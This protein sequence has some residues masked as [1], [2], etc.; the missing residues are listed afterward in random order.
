[1]ERAQ[2]FNPVKL[3]M[4]NNN[5]KKNWNSEET[6]YKEFLKNLKKKYLIAY[7]FFVEYHI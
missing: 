5:P 4:W 2:Y 3:D 6:V 7:V 1:M